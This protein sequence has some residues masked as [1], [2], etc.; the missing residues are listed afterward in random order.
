MNKPGSL[1]SPI[2]LVPKPLLSWCSSVWF[3]MSRYMP[4]LYY[5]WQK[6]VWWVFIPT[7][8]CIG[9]NGI[10]AHLWTQKGQFCLLTMRLSWQA[11]FTQ[12]I[13]FDQYLKTQPCIVYQIFKGFPRLVSNQDCVKWKLFWVTNW[14]KSNFELGLSFFEPFCSTLHKGFKALYKARKLHLQTCI[15]HHT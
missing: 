9:Q 10:G 15:V 8:R 14:L 3:I 13:S 11:C 7:D 6:H 2:T 1:Y 12:F 4:T 5:Q